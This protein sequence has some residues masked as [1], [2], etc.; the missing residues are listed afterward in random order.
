[1]RESVNT[2][3]RTSSKAIAMIWGSWL[4]LVLL[5]AL[6]NPLASEMHGV[7]GE[8]AVV[9]HMAV[10]LL[11]IS[12]LFAKRI[13][14]I[15]A[16]SLVL[17]TALVFWDLNF[18]DV[19][20][21]TNSGADTEM[22]YYWAVE[23]GEDLGLLSADI[24]GGAFS[25]MFGLLF[26]LT[27]PIRVF[28]QYTNALFGLTSVI[29]IHQML[30]QLPL[31]DRSAQRALAL[32]AFLPN[33]LVL[34][35][36]FLRESVIALLVTISV[37]NFVRWYQSGSFRHIVVAIGSVL[38]AS[39][40]HAGVIAV[41]VG[42]IFVFLAYQ[43]GKGRFGP[44]WKTVPYLIL[45]AAVVFLVATRYPDLFLG[46]FEQ[47]ESGE[48]VID[49]ANFRGGGSKYL[50]DVEVQSYG[51]LVRYGPL[52]SLYFLAAPLPWDFR[53]LTDVFAF[54]FD[55]VFYLGSVIAFLL[56][57]HRLA[58]SERALGV[59]VLVVILVSVTVFGAGVSNSGTALR[60]R[61]KLLALFL[62][63]AALAT[64]R[65]RSELS[66]VRRSNRSNE[67][68]LETAGVPNHGTQIV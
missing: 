22:F 7:I 34:T 66:M 68:L 24:R 3:G 47:V 59:G 42:M 23:V 18:R 8:V 9:V 63:L 60:H 6:I 46:K 16:L 19:F 31:R 62:T 43:P 61:F 37:V 20:L 55:S 57:F 67:R 26:Y 35:A 15:L 64:T 50:T 1:M 2:F 11:V 45:F 4:A 27:G 56:Q 17:R 21:L 14:L 38:S 32:A 30:I 54:L 65:S 40:F 33:A 51:D 53:G 58:A 52:R 28:A 41:G 49:I 5:L 36:I 12:Q 29:L 25:K 44:G 48:D 39:I 13:A 10:T